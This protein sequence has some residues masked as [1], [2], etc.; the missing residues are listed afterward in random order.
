MALVNQGQKNEVVQGQKND[1]ALEEKKKRAASA[2]RFKAKREEKQK[3]AYE[4]ALALRDELVKA[5]LFDN[6][7]DKAKNL[8]LE[9]CKDPALKRST[10]GGGI[11]AQLF[12]ATPKVG[13]KVTLEEAFTRTFKGKSTLD[14]N[15]KRWAEKGIIVE[16]E[17]NPTKMLE[18]TYT[19]K[20]LPEG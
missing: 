4:A 7:S 6:L 11:F 8:V 5:K 19:I 16:C 17:I 14:Y 9:L 18:S 2:A 20:A 15:C 10:G 12:G 1:A 3:A 13:D